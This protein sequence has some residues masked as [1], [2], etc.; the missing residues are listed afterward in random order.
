MALAR[1]PD[2][3]PAWRRVIEGM[4]SGRLLVEDTPEGRSVAAIAAD[5]Y[6]P[7]GPRVVIG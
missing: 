4:K 3:E 5:L 6:G 7:Q 2:L 1:E